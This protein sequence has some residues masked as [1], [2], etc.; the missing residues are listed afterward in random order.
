[1]CSP[2]AMGIGTFAQGAFGALQGA[3]QARA[4]NRAAIQSYEHA[5]NVRKHEWYQQL[6]VWGA[7]RNKYFTDI[8]EN[9]LAAQRGYS[10]AQVGLNRVWEGAAQANEGALIKYLQ[11]HGTMLAKGRTGRSVARMQ[12]L[13][14]GQLQRFAGRQAF[15]MTRAKHSYK[16]NV[17]DIRRQQ[18]SR[19]SRLHANVAFQPMPDLAP[20][21]PQLENESAMP[22]LLMA[23]GQGLLSYGMAGGKF[24]KGVKVPDTGIK[25][26]LNVPWD[27]SGSLTNSEMLQHSLK[28]DSSAFRKPNWFQRTFGGGV[29][30][31]SYWGL[32][33]GLGQ[34]YMN[35]PAFSSFYLPNQPQMSWGQQF[36]QN[37][38]TT[39]GDK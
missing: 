36:E 1:M 10:Q 22:G 15:A 5:L 35:N 34:G 23:A 32:G 24:G 8:T 20:P 29:S 37:W 38:D 39:W 31:G 30:K 16:E 3:S 12:T 17:E 28:M 7:K 25:T 11:N 2:L 18:I 33:L 9:D 27:T 14:L 21:P 19:R 6:S 13:E 4:R 26:D